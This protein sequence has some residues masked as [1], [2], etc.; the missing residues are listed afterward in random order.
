MPSS[1][2][3]EKLAKSDAN[4]KGDFKEAFDSLIG[5][6]FIGIVPGLGVGLWNAGITL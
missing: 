6:L 4:L 5:L 1:S 3:E 2:T